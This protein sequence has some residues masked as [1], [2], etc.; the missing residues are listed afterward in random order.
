MSRTGYLLTTL[1]CIRFELEV[2][3]APE[4]CRAFVRS[5]ECQEF[6]GGEFNRVVHADNDNSAP[7]IEIV[8]AFVRSGTSE[9]RIPHESTV[10]T[11]L[12]HGV[13]TLSLPRRDGSSATGSGIFVSLRVDRELDHG[14]GRNSDG[15]GFAV[16]GRV[17]EGLEIVRAIHSLPC[18]P[19]GHNAYVAGQ[20]LEDPVKILSARLDP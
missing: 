10:R 14:G 19:V 18:K 4:S 16:F 12:R 1:G 3:R 2:A 6:D 13:G 7:P 5:V 11:G 15:R 8:Q 20:M 9:S 17:R